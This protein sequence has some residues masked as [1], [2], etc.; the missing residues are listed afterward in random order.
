MRGQ[1]LAF[2]CSS[3]GG[4]LMSMRGV[5]GA[6]TVE[7]ETTQEILSATQYL[8]RAILDANPS[9]CPEDLASVLFTLT[10]DL[11][12]VHPA[13]GAREM[14]WENVPLMCAQ[15][16]PVPGSLRH[17]IRVLLHWNTDLPQADIH[18][19][20]LKDAVTLRPDIC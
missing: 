12:A 19:V 17:C 2:F 11:R 5:R 8:L 9:L 10:E 6:I 13:R 18:H 7:N 16:I 14:G 4:L 20:Y 3:T 1:R 15:E